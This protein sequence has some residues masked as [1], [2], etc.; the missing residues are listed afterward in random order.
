[1]AAALAR[2]LESINI[3]AP[4]TVEPAIAQ[5]V[6]AADWDA[7]IVLSDQLAEDITATPLAGVIKSWALVATGQ[8]DAGLAQLADSGKILARDKSGLP[9]FIQV[10]LA[11]MTE[12]LG[13]QDEASDMAA[14]VSQSP[15]L[16]AKA[17]LQTAGILARA[18]QNQTANAL[19]KK[20]PYSFDHDQ[21]GPDQLAPPGSVAEFIANAII[22]AA[23]DKVA[24][25]RANLGAIEN[26]LDY[27]ITNLMNIG[28]RTADSR[29]RLQDA[30]YAL[31]SSRLAKAQVIQQAGTQMLSQAN[32]MTQL[33]LDLLR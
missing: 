1:M 21:I 33:V 12:Y 24:Q 11:L 15:T 26:R 13:Y 19:L 20:L 5:A 25:M 17:A 30:D 14:R 3:K 32:Q 2:Q 29:S 6:T 18:K 7:V 8:G 23:L 16:P 27:T 9:S 28:E 31:E 4:F 22:D 10:Q